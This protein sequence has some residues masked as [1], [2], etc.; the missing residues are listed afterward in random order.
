[1]AAPVSAREHPP[2]TDTDGRVWR[3]N[4]R[5]GWVPD[6]DPHAHPLTFQALT[7]QV[8]DDGELHVVHEDSDDD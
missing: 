6:D 4:G 5:G 3:D 8:P 1:M 7:Q 2:V